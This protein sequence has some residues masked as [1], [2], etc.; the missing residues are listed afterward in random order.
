[1]ENY[2]APTSGRDRLTKAITRDGDLGDRVAVELPLEIRVNGQALAV[3]MRTPGHDDQLALGFLHGEGLINQPAEVGPSL[4]FESNVVEVAAQ[5]L[6]EPPTRRFYTTS[7]CGICSKGALEEVAVVAPHLK[8][9]PRVSRSLLASLPDLM[10]GHQEGF[11]ASGGLHAAAL[12]STD[13]HLLAVYEDVGRHN[14]LDKV[15]GWALQSGEIPLSQRILCVS[16]RISFELV[17]KAAVAG[18]P[19][20]VGV[21]APTSLALDLAED[22]SMTVCGFARE[23][24]L[25]VYCGTERIAAA[26]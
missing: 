21:S 9:G 16:G 18:C 22:R 7:S 8:P 19:I 20:L 4:D 12:F 6:R 26:S 24:Q 11:A 10:T 14:A 1:L 3:T 23:G 13:G 17:Q 15:V 5:L 2:D 25:N